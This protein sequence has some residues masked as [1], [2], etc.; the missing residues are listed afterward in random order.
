[1]YG[2][3]NYNSNIANNIKQQSTKILDFQFFK[4]NTHS[5]TIKQNIICSI[6]CIIKL[7]TQASITIKSLK[8]INNQSVNNVSR[9]R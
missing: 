4:H 9:P 5:L 3:S 2:K 7:I 8:P 1:M 6:K